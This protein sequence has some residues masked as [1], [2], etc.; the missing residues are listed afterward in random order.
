MVCA[1]L[2]EQ[3]RKGAPIIGSGFGGTK[4][5]KICTVRF[6]FKLTEA[7]RE[8]AEKADKGS[9]ERWTMCGVCYY[10]WEQHS[11]FL[12]PSGDSTFVPLLDSK[13]PF[14]HTK[15]N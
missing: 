3:I 8:Q 13:Q 14:L 1:W 6:E 7:E 9:F 10:T 11:G 15:E 4:S 12:C 2:D 5:G